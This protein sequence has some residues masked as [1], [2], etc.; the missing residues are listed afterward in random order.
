MHED[1]GAVLLE[2]VDLVVLDL[3]LAQ[4]LAKCDALLLLPEVAQVLTLVHDGPATRGHLEL[5]LV[6][7]RPGDGMPLARGA[8]HVAAR[9]ALEHGEPG[10]VQQV[11]RARDGLEHQIL[12]LRG[13]AGHLSAFRTRRSLNDLSGGLLR[14]CHAS[15]K[16]LVLLCLYLESTISLRSDCE[17]AA[18]LSQAYC[19]KEIHR[20][21]YLEYSINSPSKTI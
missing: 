5:R 10:R 15:A 3:H 7:G 4:L 11:L 12:L 9:V 6:L 8:G 2:A 18:S 14:F 16:S 17:P 21:P 20:Q 1:H 19:H 13:L